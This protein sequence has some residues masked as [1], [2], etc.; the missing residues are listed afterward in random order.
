M[1]LA[2]IGGELATGAYKRQALR[3]QF[4]LT[5]DEAAELQTAAELPVCLHMCGFEE[6]KPVSRTR[7]P[8]GYAS[9]GNGIFCRV[10]K[11][12]R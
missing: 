1:T 11:A 10:G 2:A 4:S 8:S 12:K 6:Y 7:T 9:I 5:W 3:R